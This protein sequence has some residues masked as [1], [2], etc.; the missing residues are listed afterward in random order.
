MIAVGLL[1]VDEEPL[2][3]VQVRHGDWGRHGGLLQEEGGDE[4]HVQ[5]HDPE[6]LPLLLRRHP[7]HQ[8]RV[9]EQHNTTQHKH[10]SSDIMAALSMIHA[11]SFMHPCKIM[12]IV[13]DS[14]KTIHASMQNHDHSP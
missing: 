10:T 1:V 13:H 7:G 6:Q 3:Y 11:K 14:C 5:V 2:P 4:Q 12:I 8:E 9:G